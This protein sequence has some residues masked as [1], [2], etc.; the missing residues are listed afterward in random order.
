[1]QL[2]RW[3]QRLAWVFLAVLLV[4]SL[5]AD[6]I[7][8]AP[9]EKQFRD[10]PN[11]SPSPAFLL[12]TDDLGRDRFSRLLHGTRVSLLLAPAAALLAVICAG[13]VGASAA[14]AGRRSSTGKKLDTLL[15]GATDLTLSLPWLFLLIAARAALPLDVSPWI[16]VCITFLILGLLGWAG[17]ARVV[18]SGVSEILG[19]SYV[20]AARSRGVGWTR[21]MLRHVVPNTRPVLAAQ[22]WSAVPVFILAEANLGLLGLGVTE[23]MP[24]WGT[25][26]KEME[27]HFASGQPLFSEC[28]IFAP[29]VLILLVVLSLTVIF[30]SEVTT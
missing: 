19:S 2:S 20:L 13:L 18:R 22:F 4:C 14:A 29:A 10:V 15:M 30:P 6:W 5:A 23:P 17:P 1:M 28:W 3:L 16:S 25:L 7:A 24:S 9:P 27:G 8:P 12:G 26:I 11:A 21:I